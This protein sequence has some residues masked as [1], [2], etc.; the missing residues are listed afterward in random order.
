MISSCCDLDDI[1][2][3]ETSIESAHPYSSYFY[4]FDTI[5]RIYQYRDAVHGFSEQFHRVYGITDGAGE[6]I[7]VEK[8]ESNG[9]LKEVY[10][11]NLDSL[12]VLDHVVVNSKGIKE[13]ATIYKN[14]L[15]PE[16]LGD[17]CSF[18]SKFSGRDSTIMLM[19]WFRKAVSIETRDV[20]S[21]QKECLT[22]DDIWRYTELNPYTRKE[23]PSIRK[24]KHVYAK[25]IG[26]VEWMSENKKTHWVLEEIISQKKWIKL[27]SR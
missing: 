1:G 24:G 8:Y 27:I 11:F 25:G 2:T 14:V 21:K 26:L 6:H 12:N 19:E 15:L 18:A 23:R 10:N 7:I 16:K 9:R 20:M 22:L 3:S 17:S 5:P 4:P 13:K